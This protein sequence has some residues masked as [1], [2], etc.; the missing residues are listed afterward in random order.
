MKEKHR[1]KWRM[2]R[3]E[4]LLFM[5]WTEDVFWHGGVCEMKLV[6]V[7]TL[8]D[9]GVLVEEGI[10]LCM[11]HVVI[12]QSMWGVSSLFDSYRHIIQNQKG[13]KEYNCHCRE[14]LEGWPIGH[15]FERT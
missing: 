11:L 7:L 3:I 5:A 1:K 4:S 15:E 12:Q 14:V 9:Y 6:M 10:G 8:I 13:P 2:W